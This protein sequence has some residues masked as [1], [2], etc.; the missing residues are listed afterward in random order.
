MEVFQSETE[1]TASCHLQEVTSFL[2][3]SISSAVRIFKRD[4]VP[5]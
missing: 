5:R 4:R 2:C 3:D 1:L